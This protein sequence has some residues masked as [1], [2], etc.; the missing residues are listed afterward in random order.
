MVLDNL[1]SALGV[2]GTALMLLA[3]LALVGS[4]AIGAVLRPDCGSR[5]LQPRGR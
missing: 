2:E 3:I 1:F 5:R 4:P